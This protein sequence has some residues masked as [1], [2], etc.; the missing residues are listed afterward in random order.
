MA[1]GSCTVRPR[2]R[3]EDGTMTESR[4]WNDLSDITKDYKTTRDI[5]TATRDDNFR[6]TWRN[7]DYDEYNEPKIGSLIKETDVAEKIPELQLMDY[8]EREANRGQGTAEEKS[9]RFNES[10]GLNGIFVAVPTGD[11]VTVVK[12]DGAAVGKAATNARL[13]DM[14]EKMRDK[15]AGWGVSV[16]TLTELEEKM[17]VDGVTDFSK[18]E[19][20]ANGIVELIRLAKGQRGEVALSEEFAHFAVEVLM[21]DPL[22]ERGV[23][24]L[25]SEAV[26][27]KVL[28]AEYERYEKEYNGDAELLAKECLGKLV[29]DHWLGAKPIEEGA[30][31]GSILRRIISRIKEFF[32]VMDEIAI[33]N[34]LVSA[35]TAANTFARNVM[36]GKYDSQI[37]KDRIARIRERRNLFAMTTDEGKKT[38]EAARSVAAILQKQRQ[39][40]SKTGINNAR[41][42]L[43]HE[44]AE[45]EGLSSSDWDSL[46]YAS[47]LSVMR[48][49]VDPSVPLAG[50]L[51]GKA[52]DKTDMYLILRD[53]TY[54]PSNA[55]E[56]TEA[57]R[58]EE[59]LDLLNGAAEFCNGLVETMKRIKE[60]AQRIDP[61]DETQP[62][63][64]RCAAVRQV[65]YMY[66]MTLNASA[67]LINLS[68]EL[69]QLPELA[70]EKTK[71]A[72]LREQAWL[73]ARQ[74]SGLNDYY[75]KSLEK[76]FRE[77]LKPFT[78]DSGREIV[79]TTGS[80][81]G[82]KITVDSLIEEMNK[83][84]AWY[85]RWLS[86][87]AQANNETLKILDNVIK[88]Y[89]DKAEREAREYQKKLV[90]IGL[91]M[92]KRGTKDFEWMYKKD[93][94]GHKTEYLI[95]R[96]DFDRYRRD[97]AKMKEDLRA[98]YPEWETTERQQYLDEMDLWYLAHCE[99]TPS[100]SDPNKMVAKRNRPNSTYEDA[101]FKEV[102]KDPNKKYV[103]LQ[104]ME[105]YRELN[106]MI[107]SRMMS[108]EYGVEYPDMVR[109]PAVLRGTFERVVHAGSVGDAVDVIGKGVQDKLMRRSDDEE[110]G[111]VAIAGYDVNGVSG[112]PIG[113]LPVYY[114]HLGKNESYDDLN[115]D[116]VSVM[117]RYAGMACN[118]KSMSGV[119]N[120]IEV[121]KDAIGET[122][123][124]KEGGKYRVAGEEVQDAQKTKLKD[125]S[126]IYKRL[127]SYIEAQVYGQQNKDVGTFQPFGFDTHIDKNKA[128]DTVNWLTAMNSY[129]LNILSGI[130]N[131]STGVVMMNI[132]SASREFWSASDN[133]WADKT[134][135]RY[136][137]DFIANMGKR[138]R[139]DKLFLFDEYMDVQQDGD[140]EIN[141]TAFNRKN[142]FTRLLSKSP[143]FF[144]NNCGEHYMSNRTALALAHNYKL[145]QKDTGAEVCLW[146]AMEVVTRKV[147]D[148]TITEIKVNDNFV[149]MDG[150]PFTTEDAH[151]FRRKAAA[152]NQ[153]MH[154]IYNNI[155]KNE[156]QR[157]G[158]G[159][160]I[161]MFRKWIVP[162]FYRRFAGLE[163]NLDIGED[164]YSEGY[165]RT[166]FNYLF[167]SMNLREVFKYEDDGTWHIYAG[168]MTFH[169]L[170]QWSKCDDKQKANMRRA[171]HELSTVMILMM[172][173]AGLG[174]GDDDDD[175]YWANLAAYE[176]RRLYSEVSAQTPIITIM[177]PE[178]VRI[179]KS[180]AAGISTIE[181]YSN[182]PFG[183]TAPLT[184]W[185]F[186]PRENGRFKGLTEPD[187]CLIKALPLYNTVL[188]GLHPE[189]QITY[190]KQTTLF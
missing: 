23:R 17:G 84:I 106:K 86:S 178:L 127:T 1:E 87:M 122:V 45:E 133:L 125:D 110:F 75:K 73:M 82:E 128:A 119:V 33:H 19:D 153:R 34:E 98:K 7:L 150:T 154:G 147:G 99:T 76:V 109:A 74:F 115:T 138:V 146:D 52:G 93:D 184:R 95:S 81:K 36:E 139:T 32:G 186:Q 88:T 157:Y 90:Q 168:K 72:A 180:P 59:P 102:M 51:S 187:I 149:K 129:A 103:Y 132:E 46:D 22:V 80:R 31:F 61:G 111:S 116:L 165:Y 5:Y 49:G 177:A 160:M 179:I 112:E 77:F 69:E 16:G 66:Q 67:A 123:V 172:L 124:E 63:N 162:S 14:N 26:Q 148:Q 6:E 28:G 79:I 121:V 83:D 91:D 57:I 142:I 174:I 108:W 40:M 92:E 176:T 101:R 144:F 175:D 89:K 156:L 65:Q 173:I 126:N 44:I 35:T 134:Y 24:S 30:S 41:R 117:A 182:L 10:S 9:E 39:V 71:I 120:T 53:M 21:D 158:V 183:L 143:L 15:L 62:L 161:I 58:K 145:K 25:S 104:M 4:L 29:K 131:V 152:I 96:I 155:D 85:D 42:Q 164:Y 18:V 151:K 13:K 107:P 171:L 159:R 97:E 100:R 60:D 56:L 3:K 48:P 169:L 68:D 181:Q 137:P 163:R 70:G 11:S 50:V 114:Q 166:A 27:R 38:L 188:K 78:S 167:D 136:L 135:A 47:R 189:E 118:F 12:K 113:T 141:E 94:S 54:V 43:G 2:V 55:Q 64:A 185:F 130:S 105:V 20:V 8:A 170:D 37:T 140:K 190:L